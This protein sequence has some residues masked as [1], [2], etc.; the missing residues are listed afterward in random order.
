MNVFETAKYCFVEG[1]RLLEANDLEGAEAQFAR[2]LELIPDR[3]STLNNLAAIKIRLNQFGEAGEFARKVIAIEDK[4]PEAWTNLGI[5]LAM[6]ERQEEA[7]RAY[8]RAL[9]C[10]STYARAWLNKAAALLE[11]KRYDQALLACDEALKLEPHQHEGLHKK[12]LILKELGRPDEAR[13]AYVTSLAMRVVSS[14]V[15][16][17]ERHA[18]QA[19][20]ALIISPDPPLDE[21]MKSF[22]ALHLERPNFPIQLARRLQR[23][24]HFTFVF[25]GDA[26]S[27]SARK[28]IPRPDFV[29]NN[30]VNG[31][32]I[33]SHDSLPE[34]I[35]LV[36]SFN[37]PVVNHPT[38]VVQTTRDG[39][40]KLLENIPG[41]VVPKTMR[42]S[43]QG[44]AMEQLVHEIEAQF[45]YPLI[46]RSL[47]A[48]R[49]VGMNKADS[50]EELVAA[51]SSDDLKEGFFVTE[52]VDTRREDELF[53]KIRAAIVHDEIV[54]VR[55]DYHP[56]WKVH[57]GRSGRRVSFYLE[58]PHLLEI[59]RQICAD[60]EKEFGRSA[61]QSLR[62][63]RNRIPLDIF[64]IDFNVDA[65]GLLV[66]Y[67]ANATMNLLSTAQKEVA[68]PKEAD[69]RLKEAFRRYLG[70]LA[71]CHRRKGG[72]PS[73]TTSA[74]SV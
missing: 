20:D 7:L 67:E 45:D 54:V 65:D 10:N 25:K 9:D 53:R 16:I 27:D 52:F 12:S 49:G 74:N 60:P 6:T 26:A 51:L 8:D 30:C 40:A 70:S 69:D 33:L 24:F 43:S 63:I 11:L 37:V 41:V 13:K 58:N 64:G 71:N 3:A 44:I 68:N 23:D 55:V 34:L 22:E 59:E 48:Q 39:T 61:T 42:F 62:A 56:D 14:P 36:D 35:G 47:A 1:L 19:A 31:E 32:V 4:S 57:G 38:K 21:S 5:T 15:L 2:S 17:G 46:T 66:F 73:N 18:N 29:I 50:R 28:Q 72:T